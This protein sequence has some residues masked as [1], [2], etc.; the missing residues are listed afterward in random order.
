VTNLV[1]LKVCHTVQPSLGLALLGCTPTKIG[2]QSA[3]AT[4]MTKH[5]EVPGQAADRLLVQFAT[6][7]QH[8]ELPLVCMHLRQ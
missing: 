3:H 4:C 2:F 5:L 1:T 7:Y 8:H 6:Q